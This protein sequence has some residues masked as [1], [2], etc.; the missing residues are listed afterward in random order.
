MATLDHL[1]QSLQQHFDLT[2]FRPG[3]EEAIRHVVA[4]QHTLVVMPTG[5]G[6]S[7]CYQLP[8]V[9][10]DK[11]LVLVISPLIA[12]MQDQVRSLGHRGVPAAAL[13]SLQGAEE[14]ATVLRRMGAGLYRLVY[15]APERLQSVAFAQALP[16]GQVRLLAV[17]EA[18]CISRWGHDFRPSY[19]EIHKAWE[20]VGRPTVLAATATATPV[21]QDDIVAQLHLP[22]AARVVTG[23]D[24]PNLFFEVVQAE[25]EAAKLDCLLAALSEEA[26]GPVIVY[27]GTRRVAEELAE[28]IAQVTGRSAAHYH[29][30]LYP[31]ERRRVQADFVRDRLQV[32]VATNAFGLGVDK[33]NVRAVIHWDIPGSLESY[34]QEAGRAGRDGQPAHCMLIY[35]PADVAL[36]EWFINNDA[37]DADGLRRL[38]EALGAAPEGRDGRRTVDEVAVRRK[39]RLNEIK[40]R[41]GISLLQGAGV[42]D[43]QGRDGGDLVFTLDAAAPFDPEAIMGWVERFREH[44]RALLQEMIDYAETRGCRRRAILDYFGD[45]SAT[46]AG[47]CCDN[48]L[49]QSR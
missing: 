37:P 1:R 25:D 39:A 36:Q 47:R 17:D 49:A 2:D 26:G 18:H 46:G 35:S 44:K 3:Q 42:L 16:A 24:R 45:W 32:L 23:F 13:H 12:L 34:Y 6:K 27:V 40:L 9:L 10:E 41:V 30:G 5:S 28:V 48:C 43:D 19:L 21:V 8:A 38:R 29:G 15:V 22:E 11:G 7:L 33:A 20:A 4:G 14:Q 31:A